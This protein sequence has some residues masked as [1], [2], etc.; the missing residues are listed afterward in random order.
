MAPALPPSADFRM[1]PALITVSG[2]L[3]MADPGAITISGGLEMAPAL[4]LIDDASGVIDP[5]LRTRGPP[6]P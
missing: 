3:D 5:P 1:A 4:P 6:S 2:G